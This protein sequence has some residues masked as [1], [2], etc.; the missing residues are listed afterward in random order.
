MNFAIGYINA[1]SP[2]SHGL[3]FEAFEATRLVLRVCH[4]VV[5][6]VGRFLIEFSAKLITMSR[7]VTSCRE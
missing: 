4:K 6:C 5:G 7:N 1:V 2:N 3:T